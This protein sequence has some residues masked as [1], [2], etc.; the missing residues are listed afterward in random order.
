VT[1]PNRPGIHVLR[2][3]KARAHALTAAAALAFLAGLSG[4]AAAAF[5]NPP[6]STHTTPGA[7][8]STAA[9]TSSTLDH[10]G[11]AAAQA[12]G[13]NTHPAPAA[14]A[15]ANPAPAA[16]LSWA[17][18][19][20]SA[21]DLFP[22]GKATDQSAIPLSPDQL[23]NAR[24]IVQTGQ[25]LGLQPRAWVIAVSTALQESK[26]TNLGNLGA[27]NDHDSLGLFQ[28]RPASGWGSPAQINNPTYAATAFYTALEHVAGWQ[29]MSVTDAA[30]AVQ[31]SAYP[32]AYAQWEQQAGDIISG[33]YGYGP[34]ANAAHLN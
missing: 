20:P 15:K 26:L 8:A 10:V 30:Q 9:P 12:A 13:I 3:V 11:A 2:S 7:A 34:Y 4:P 14:P 19:N 32:D 22:H 23:R 28:Q 17:Q 21:A 16:P 27:N 31:V 33:L 6:A 25:K 18:V 29:G 1:N 5:A 24:A